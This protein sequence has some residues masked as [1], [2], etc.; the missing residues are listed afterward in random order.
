MPFSVIV[1]AIADIWPGNM[2]D[3]LMTMGRGGGSSEEKAVA[4]LCLDPSYNSRTAN[5]IRR[6]F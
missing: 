6:C 2:Y 3:C 5:S 4:L 1:A